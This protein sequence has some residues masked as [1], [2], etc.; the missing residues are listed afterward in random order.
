MSIGLPPYQ[1]RNQGGA[2]LTAK[3]LTK[4]SIAYAL[5]SIAWQE[6]HDTQVTPINAQ[7]ISYMF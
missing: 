7:N 5:D 6:S 2:S 3:L 1:K 4:S